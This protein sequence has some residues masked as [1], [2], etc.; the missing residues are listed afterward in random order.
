MWS[1]KLCLLDNPPL[2][3]KRCSETSP[4]GNK[5][6]GCGETPFEPVGTIGR[7]LDHAFGTTCRFRSATIFAQKFHFG[8]A[9]L[10]IS[11]CA[12]LKKAPELFRNNLCSKVWCNSPL[13]EPARTWSALT[14][15]KCNCLEP[16]CLFESCNLA[17]IHAKR[18]TVIPKNLGFAAIADL[19]MVTVGLVCRHFSRGIWGVDPAS[20]SVYYCKI[21]YYLIYSFSTLSAYIL[22]GKKIDLTLNRNL[23]SSTNEPNVQCSS[24]RM[25]N[26]L[27]LCFQFLP[28]HDA[29]PSVNLSKRASSSH[30]VRRAC[31]SS[32]A[33][34]WSFSLIF[35]LSS[36]SRW[37][38]CAR[39]TE[40]ALGSFNAILCQ[41]RR[42]VARSSPHA[43]SN[44]KAAHR[45]SRFLRVNPLLS[46]CCR[47]E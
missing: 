34:L 39:R 15:K 25:F 47:F 29:L 24:I 8:H 44:I 23:A 41:V 45:R 27:I 14:R 9:K 42:H 36:P 11:S 4:K 38:K 22:I 13:T 33:L 1:D 40:R 17:A 10:T 20:T 21:W 35:R 37:M 46:R 43:I 2:I 7:L 12:V 6:V 31:R 28:W 18:M 32:R 16:H 5:G 3:R 19:M 30:T 26:W